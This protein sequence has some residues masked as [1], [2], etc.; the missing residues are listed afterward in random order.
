MTNEL[1]LLLS[2]DIPSATPNPD[3]FLEIAGIAHYENVNSRIYAHFL[4]SEH[5]GIRSAFMDA[6]LE[7]I[8]EKSGKQLDIQN[9]RAQLEDPTNKNYRIDILIK[10]EVNQ[11][12]IIIENKIYH[13]LNNDL[14]NYWEHVQ[15]KDENKVG[16]LLTLEPHYIPEVVKG[17]FINI[18]HNDWINRIRKNGLPMGL[19]ANYYQ[20][21]ND[22]ATTIDRLTK[23]YAMNEET[24]FYFQH[25][26]KII[27]AK[28][29]MDEAYHFLENQLDI[30]A[31]KLN[32]SKYGSAINWKNF[33]DAEK[34]F[35]SYLTVWYDP[36]INGELK[37]RIF[38]ELWKE[39]IEY[40]DE[41]TSLLKDNQ[42]FKKMYRGESTKNYMH[43]GVRDYTLTLTELEHFGEHLYQL[44]LSDFAETIVKIIQYRYPDHNIDKWLP[45][46]ENN[47]NSDQ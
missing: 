9:Y 42:Q 45:N 35:H 20:Y 24:H 21:I 2:L 25:A 46:F 6:L 32:W 14:L 13:I 36:I 19:P 30:L 10:D 15:F 23:S 28:R 16:V 33:W 17:K 47:L 29:T 26:P 39:D 3:G 43:F 34:E 31:A 22:F 12:A 8:E 5:E 37:F 11:S 27:A 18:N 40:A 4:N 7:L 38:I 1:Q 44:I 41:L